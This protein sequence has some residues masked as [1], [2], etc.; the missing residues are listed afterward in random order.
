VVFAGSL[1]GVVYAEPG[2]ESF[3]LEEVVVMA[4][5][6]T[7]NLQEVPDTVVAFSGEL[8]ERANMVQVRDVT[9]R[10]PNVSIE[11]SL[12]PTST[13]I[14]S[15]GVIS[16]RNGEPAIAMVI[17]GVQIASASE[18]SQAFH[19]VESIEMLK[20]PQ[21]ALYGRNAIGG[22]LLITSKAPTEEL[23]GRV[24]AGIGNNDFMEFDGALSG[25]ITDNLGFRIS[26]NF[27]D[28]SGTIENEYIDEL[29]SGSS[30]SS[31]LD[32]GSDSS[33]YADFETNKDYR[34]QL[35][36]TPS[37]S[38]S[39]DFRYNNSDL[40]AGAYWY[41]PHVRKE[42]SN[43]YIEFPISTDVL[44]VAFRTI[45]SA[46]L[47]FDYEIDAGTFTSIT[48]YTETEERYGVPYEGRGGNQMGDVDFMNQTYVDRVSATL[49]PADAEILGTQLQ[50]VGAH[51]FYEI[52]SFSQELRF[53]SDDEGRFRWTAG[54]YL[55][56][57]ERAD[58]IRADLTIPGSLPLESR[59]DNGLPGPTDWETTSG[60]IFDTAN[61][62]D[63]TAW[64]VFF[65][66][67]YDITD[68]LTATFAIRYDEDEREITRLDGP[69][70]N[71]GGEGVGFTSLGPECTVGVAGCVPRGFTEKDTF[72]AAQPK[73][74]L[75]WTPNDNLM[76]YGT[77]ARGFRSGGF[78]ASGA[79]LAETYDKE[80]IDS[81]ELGVKST[82]L[83]GRLRLNSAV[84]YQDYE[85]AQV[86]EFDGAIFVQS[87]FNI[88]ESE[89]SG[90]EVSFDWAATETLILSGGLGLLDSE[91]KEFDSQITDTLESEL[92]A[93]ITNTVK[94]TPDSQKEFDNNFEG[95][96]L[97]K[98][99]HTTANLSLL[100]ELPLSWFGGSTLVTLIDYRMWDDRYWWIDNTDKQDSEFVI[101]GSV[102]LQFTDQ[103][104]AVFWCKNCTDEFYDYSVEPAEMVLFGGPSKDIYYQARERTFGVKLNYRF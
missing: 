8:A 87:L 70:V 95:N 5:K 99:P 85:N 19:D 52:E 60:L 91:I 89:I 47:K 34:L 36:W 18:V 84:F 63:N 33:S 39:L 41:R 35:F 13:F 6:R 77:A 78:N 51:N 2:S 21:G 16:T 15:R 94:L 38:A 56:L 55:L 7:E 100:H 57:T 67:D 23:S 98:F 31:S 104:E 61:T 88:P 86:F 96:K 9:A 3:A 46:S 101:D 76:L 103:L 82:L 54:A 65:S 92:N 59:L 71:T 37:D 25:P 93:R 32:L 43:D 28:F 73:F 44:T 42:T 79:L 53:S 49:D 62:Q 74:S 64:A 90:L 75:A 12:S 81:Y 72:T 30:V 24:T 17:D 1:S 69:T 83:D 50:G 97:V 22:A 40:E 29:T 14:A 26:G 68:T 45:E 66:G 10:I 48:A 4:R 11:E 102:A 20:G 27:R 58:S 80:V